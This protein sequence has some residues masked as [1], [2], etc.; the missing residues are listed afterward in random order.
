MK[1]TRPILA[2]LLACFALAAAAE[3]PIPVEDFFRLPQYIAMRISPD[4][5]H[6]AAMAPVKGRQNLVVLDVPPKNARALSAFENKDVV[7]FRWLGSKRLLL[8]TG[9]FATRAF[10]SRGGALYAVDID[11]GGVRQLSEGS[12]DDERMEGG[13]RAVARFLDVVRLLPGDSEDFIAQEVSFDAGGHTQM[14]DLFRVNSRTGRRTSISFGKPDS[15]EG[16]S[17]VVDN[18]GVARVLR[19]SGK[20]TTRIHYRASE[21]APW[22]KLDEFPS[23]E[24][25]WLPV[26]IDADDKTL[27]AS[28]YRGR[29]KSAIVRYD[30]AARAFGE[31]VAQHPQVGLGNLVFDEGKA[32]GVAYDADRAG[33]AMFDPQ[34]QRLQNTADKAFPDAVN[35]LNWSRDRSRVLIFSYSDVSPGTFYLLDVKKGR[36]EYLADRSPW[37]KPKEMSPMQPVRYAARDGLEI[38]GYLTLPRGR[39]PKDLPLVVF[40]H[41]GPWVEGY[42]WRFDSDVQFLASRGYAVLQ[43]NFRGTTRYGWKHF[44]ASFGQWGLAMQ[45]DITD[46]VKWVV[47]QG[48]ADPKRVCIYGASYGGYATMMGLAKTPE[49]FRCGIDYVGVTDIPLFLTMTWA[50]YSN[51]E[52]IEYDARTMVGDPDRDAKRLR[53]TSPDELADRIK[54]P[55]LMAY[56][57]ADRR[58]PIEHGTRMKAALDKV[59]AKYQWMVMDG[60][61]HGFRDPANQ[62]AFY[63]AV[64][65]FL[66]E[67]LKPARAAA[68]DAH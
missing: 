56:G 18:R 47:G 43:P 63:E 26:A 1:R 51:S 62:K 13:M 39:A 27:L 5:E 4:G 40:V 53:E 44:R 8:R 52:A 60:E 48:I 33:F 57:G 23:T 50:D 45:D 20:G 3:A 64:E 41:G 68:A 11:G 10:D 15:G 16:E 66:A 25:G 17:W 58:V 42:S 34:L 46:G 6:I 14:G 19:V 35:V 29:D 61:G 9:T 28:T 55:V 7:W 32:V 65:K 49:L 38:P 22:V 12:G 67:N 31:V 24:P 54:A 30:P 37:I 21:D 59:G 2:V 36:I